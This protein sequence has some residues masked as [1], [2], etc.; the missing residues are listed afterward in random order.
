VTPEVFIARWRGS[1]RTERSAAQEHFI[2]L[3]ALLGVDKPG[4]VDRHGHNYTFEKN[5]LKLDGTAGYADVWKKERFAW[6]YK[7]PKKNLVRA[8]AQLKQ[9]ADALENPPLLIVSDME[10]IRIHTNFTNAITKQHTIHLIDLIAPETRQLLRDCF[11][12]PERLKPTATRESVTAEAA[13]S[14]GA[15]AARLR[16]RGIE[17]GR[18]AHFLNK[19]VFCL[20]SEDIDLLPNRLFADIIDEGSRQTDDFGPM[21][22]KLFCAMARGLRF[23]TSAV[24]FFNGGLFNDADVLELGAL[25]IADLASVARLDWRAIEPSIF[26]TLFERGLDPATRRDMAMLFDKAAQASDQVPLFSLASA[27]NRVGVGIHYTDPLTISKIIEP[28]VLAPLAREWNQLKGMAAAMGARNIE[29][30]YIV[31][32]EKLAAYRVLDPACGSGNF[33]ALA[34]A[35]LKD[36]DLK[37]RKDAE[38]L[39]LPPDNPRVGPQS[40]L[41]IE[42]DP[43]AAEL[44]RLTVWIADLQWEIQNGFRIERSPIL[45]TLNGIVRGDALLK[46]DRSPAEWPVAAAVIGN[47]PFLGSKLLRTKLS[48]ERVDRLYA[49][50][51]GEVPAEADL[52]TYWFAKAWEGIKNGRFKRAGFVATNSIRGGASR[53]VLDRISR[54]GAI[55]DAW[56][57][58]PWVVD[59]AAVRV[60]LI[61]FGREAPQGVMLDGRPVQRI[62]ADLTETIDLTAS[63]PLSENQ[64]IAF[65]GPVKVGAFDIPGELARAWMQL[66]ANTNGR[67]NLDVLRPWTNG[68]DITRTPT[69]TWIID[70]GEMS[71]AEAAIYERPFEFVKQMVKPLRDNNRD[72][73]R[74]EHWWRLGRSGAAVRTAVSRL[75]RYIITPRISKYRLFTWMH[76]AVLPDSAVVAIAREDD[77]AFGVLH[78]RF[79]EAWSLRLGTSLEDRPR[80]T[81]STTF[82]TFAFPEGLTPN[83]SPASY[84]RANKAEAIASAARRLFEA[85]NEWLRPQELVKQVPEVMPGY[86]MRLIPRDGKAATELKKRTL[87]AL[88]NERPTWLNHVHQDLDAAVADAYGWSA[89]ISDDD[90]IGR[91]LELNLARP[92]QR[93][94][95]PTAHM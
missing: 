52:V 87:T 71:E 86:P 29:R 67:K 88:Y 90:A 53:R 56:D 55:F 23:G 2:D 18:I 60:S 41:G 47:P 30:E 15:I 5:V 9:Y 22:H 39:G 25:G 44:A 92:A 49:A 89:S 17:P 20:F 36:F 73:N 24:P 33:L 68:L 3:C 51:S 70:F 83:L 27:E 7:G 34:L 58:E 40:V 69:D 64:Q 43:Y 37:V 95:A 79:H 48:S 16:A 74:R 63:R 6:E 82:E 38:R 8:Y 62:N 32:R 94:A 59:G 75:P 61:C 10:E 4:N 80:Y 91:L 28:V 21:L 57:D 66:P 42:I 14:L 65:Q 50:Y 93:A 35:S 77:T 76:P 19:I 72:T 1:T 81:P 84:A 31:F 26:G 12:A 54:E 11:I 13:V 85:R 45:G 46:P 78:S